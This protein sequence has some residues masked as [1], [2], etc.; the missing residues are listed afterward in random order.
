MTHLQ[1][2]ASEGAKSGFRQWVATNAKF[3]AGTAQAKALDECLSAGNAKAQFD[4]YCEKFLS[5]TQAV[6]S[7]RADDQRQA[8][9][10]AIVGVQVEQDEPT[11]LRARITRKRTTRKAEPKA[12]KFPVGTVFLYHGKEGDTMHEVVETGGKTKRDRPAVIC[13]NET[14][15]RRPWNVKSLGIYAEQGKVE[16]VS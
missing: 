11:G 12:T 15:K 10:E 7:E 13:A 1:T 3:G 16:I 6:V 8:A 2:A 4:W 14:G 5:T 9:I